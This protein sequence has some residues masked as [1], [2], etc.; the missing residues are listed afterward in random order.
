MVSLSWAE[1]WYCCNRSHNHTGLES[2][3]LHD[4]TPKIGFSVSPAGILNLSK[5]SALMKMFFGL[6]SSF[7]YIASTIS[8]CHGESWWKGSFSWDNSFGFGFNDVLYFSY[9][10]RRAVFQALIKCWRMPGD[11]T[12][13]SYLLFAWLLYAR[14][15]LLV[16]VE[17]ADVIIFGV[18]RMRWLSVLTIWIMMEAYACVI[19]LNGIV[20]FRPEKTHICL[21]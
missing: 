12:E 3:F 7:C 9:W 8:A 17:T 13:K 6:I 5:I 10:L 14:L 1:N 20:C 16:G 18:V 2:E 11:P 4:A 15:P 19:Q 21:D